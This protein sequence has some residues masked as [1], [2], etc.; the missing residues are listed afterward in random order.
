MTRREFPKPIKVAVTKRAMR[1]GVVY[2]EKCHAQA[3]RWQIDHVRPD[4]LGG[5][6]TL[7]NA[8]LICQPCF[9][10]K[11]PKDAS[12]I[13]HAKRREAKDLRAVKPKGQIKSA[14]FAPPDK[15][16]RE[17]KQ[18]INHMLTAIERRFGVTR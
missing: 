2:C 14:G 13:A 18:P 15:P 1:E 17:P 7:E 5:E 6:P 12:A 10:E 3:K 16:K 11:N 8:M 9:E 4:G